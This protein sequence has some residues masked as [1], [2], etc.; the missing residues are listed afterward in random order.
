MGDAEP[1]KWLPAVP[2]VPAFP[3]IGCVLRRSRSLGLHLFRLIA[4][5]RDRGQGLRRCIGRRC[6][7]S[8]GGLSGLYRRDG[9]FTR[10]R[11]AEGP[12]R[13]TGR[14]LTAGTGGRGITVT[15]AYRRE[16]RQHDG[17]HRDRERARRASGR[18][19]ET[20]HHSML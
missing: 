7:L 2:R 18:E 11:S 20:V 1:K 15:A 14:G 10:N 13:T 8:F 12:R 16:R 3:A 9:L 19:K 6:A 5:K 4:R 17:D